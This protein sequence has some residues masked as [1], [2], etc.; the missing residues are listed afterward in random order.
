MADSEATAR[1]WTI[2]P[3]EKTLIQ[4][5]GI[6]QVAS[7]IAYTSRERDAANAE[8]IVAAVNQHDGLLDL[9]REFVDYFDPKLENSGWY[10]EQNEIMERARKV[11]KEVDR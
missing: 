10:Y 2:S 6:H 1:P 8:L 7:T 4:G 11:L 9:L 5:D 3:Y